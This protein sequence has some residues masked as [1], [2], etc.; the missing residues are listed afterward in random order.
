MLN[1]GCS[2]YYEARNFVFP[3]AVLKVLRAWAVNRGCCARFTRKRQTHQ[4][5]V[6]ARGSEFCRV[7]SFVKCGYKIV[8]KQ[9]RTFQWQGSQCEWENEHGYQMICWGS[10]LTDSVHRLVTDVS[11]VLWLLGVKQ[12][13]SG[14]C[15]LV[16]LQGDY[17]LCEE[18]WIMPKLCGHWCH[19]EITLIN[20][21]DCHKEYEKKVRWTFSPTVWKS[22]EAG[23][24]LHFALFKLICWH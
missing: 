23:N 6:H 19:G 10:F 9:H 24:H 21:F 11:S 20:N 7:L 8:W 16:S 15:C 12:R 14:S 18:V 1:A 5:A 2:G 13:P 4:K 3:Q 22:K 17:L